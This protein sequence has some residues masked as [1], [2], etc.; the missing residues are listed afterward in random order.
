MLYILLALFG[1]G[2]I[3]CLYLAVICLLAASRENTLPDINDV[4][5]GEIS[6]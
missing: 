2:G 1:L 6:M 4:E 5:V 3:F